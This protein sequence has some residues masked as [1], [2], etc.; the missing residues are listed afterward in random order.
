MTGS[1]MEATTRTREDVVLIQGGMGVGVSNWQLARAVAQAGERRATADRVLGV[2]SGTGAH[3][4][5]VNRLQDGDQGGH[6]QQALAAFPIPGVAEMVLDKYYGDVQRPSGSRYKLPPK[7]TELGNPRSKVRDELISLIV[8]GN[9]VEVWLARQGHR[10]P[11]G[12]NYLEKIQLPHV[13]ELFGAM[14]AGVDYV[15]MGAGIPLQV[16]GVLDRLANYQPVAYKL[17]VSGATERHEMAF[18]PGTL[19]P[20]GFGGTL[21]RPA[22][23]A[24]ITSDVLAKVLATKAT[25]FVD[26]FVIEGPLAGGHNAPPRG[27][28]KFNDRGEPIYSERDAPDLNQLRQLGR[29]FWLAG[30]HATP[31]K[32]R[33]AKAEGACGIQT[34]TVFAYCEESGLQGDLKSDLRRQAFRGELAVIADPKASPSGFPFQVAQLAGTLSD[35]RIYD[36]RRRNCSIGY[37]TQPYQTTTGGLGF[38][39]AAEPVSAYLHK[40]GKLE[41]TDGRKCICNALMAAAGL[42]L[43]SKLGVEPPIV[44]SGRDYS[45]IHK[46]MTHDRDT[47]TAADAVSYLLA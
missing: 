30:A 41:D 1:V 26:G 29:P 7:L 46:L 2:V 39:C 17:D 42:G 25:G 44:T 36:E 37:L 8:C 11:I 12:V 33:E 3:N 6:V 43:D 5:M 15:L 22:F 38:R 40:G 14:L 45:F 47:Y 21:K 31:E 27:Q 13:F 24:I 9:F 35:S 10:Q 4:L 28:P 19:M 18:A 20:S 32:L 34:G 16:P 23:L